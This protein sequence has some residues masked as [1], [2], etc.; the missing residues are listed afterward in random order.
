M[1]RCSRQS[2]PPSEKRLLFEK[3]G[4][5]GIS[6]GRKR[7]VAF[8][9]MMAMIS[10]SLHNIPEGVAVYL[11][12]LK[13][14]KS[15]LPLAIAMSLH[16][17]PEGMAVAGPIYAATKSKARAVL[18][19][20]GSGAFEVVGCALVQV[21]DQGLAQRPTALSSAIHSPLKPRADFVCVRLRCLSIASRPFSW[22]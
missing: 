7:A 21:A 19:A 4:E 1:R 6:D 10:I 18:F 14:V 3:S 16:N 5:Q 11:T 15:G 12:C 2:P 8:S 13:G 17:I 9:G 20:T 22:T